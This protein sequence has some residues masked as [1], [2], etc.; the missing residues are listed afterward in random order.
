[1]TSVPYRV[2]PIPHSPRAFSG[3][4][5][6]PCLNPMMWR[7]RKACRGDLEASLLREIG[8]LRD[9]SPPSKEEAS[10]LREQNE[11][12]LRGRNRKECGRRAGGLQP[13]WRRKKGE[14][15]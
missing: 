5:Q 8:G 1:M 4:T 9:K 7:W 11:Q 10:R 14:E 6:F 2:S 15:D 13:C 3:V 12:R